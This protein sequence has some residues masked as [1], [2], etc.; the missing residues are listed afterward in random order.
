[1]PK[2]NGRGNENYVFENGTLTDNG[3]LVK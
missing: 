2:M 1:M 3:K